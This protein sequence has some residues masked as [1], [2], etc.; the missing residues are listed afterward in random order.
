[1]MELSLLAARLSFH[2]TFTCIVVFV[3][4]KLCCCSHSRRS[5]VLV[6]CLFTV[7]VTTFVNVI[8]I[9]ITR[10]PFTA[11]VIKRST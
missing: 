8:V 1:M 4:N 3:A 2:M 10:K 6:A 11:D 5:V 9:N 7:F